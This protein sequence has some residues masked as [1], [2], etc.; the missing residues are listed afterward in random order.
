LTFPEH[1]QNRNRG[2]NYHYFQEVVVM[3]EHVR[4]HEEYLCFMLPRIKKLFL[5]KPGQV[6]YYLDAALKVYLL[7]LDKGREIL[8]DCYSKDFGR[9]AEFDPADM[10]RS[11]VL[12]VALEITSISTWVEKLKCSD[13]LAV[14]CGFIPGRTP[15]VGAFY[16]F[17]NRLWLEDKRLRKRHK[18]RLR[19]KSKKPTDAKK[20]QKLPNRRP[21]VVDR[22]VRSFRKGRFFSTKRPGRLLQE[23]FTRVFVEGSRDRG[24]IPEEMILAGDGSPF[25]SCGSPF[26]TPVCDCKAKGLYKCDCPRRYSDVYANWGYDSSRNEYFWGRNLYTLSCVNGEAELPV[27]LRFGQGSRHDSVLFAFSVVEA[28]PLFAQ[29]GLN[30]SVFIGDS[31]HDATALYTLLE[32]YGTKPVIELKQKPKSSLALN[33]QG[34]PLCPKGST[35]RY[36]G[37]EQKRSRFKWRCPKKVGPR[38]YRDRVVCEEP[39]CDSEYG[40]TVY[41]KPDWNK[42]IFTDIPRG[43]AL[44]KKLY[45]RRSAAERVN[46]RYN[47]YAL[48]TARVRENCCWYHLAHLAAMNM[49][50]DAW[51]KQEMGR[52]GLD[53]KALLLQFLGAGIATACA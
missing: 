51:V 2:I 13:V 10:L 20:G 9:P 38:R 25:E 27:F 15:S 34:I 37:Y 14:L 43:S 22:L 49:H 41:T 26:G 53:K 8:Q 47:D 52:L 24:I 7:N 42:R 4:T 30:V 40:L 46:K 23:L 17:W 50:L 19:N 1:H 5:E 36:W 21:G 44:W 6:L 11:L 48:D 32:L 16:D 45:K 35:M 28:W 3:L 29:G 39:C 12:M 33:E 31:A 18:Q